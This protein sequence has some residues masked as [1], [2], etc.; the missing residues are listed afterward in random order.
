MNIDNDGMIDTDT[1]L[2]SVINNSYW[3]RAGSIVVKELIFLD[4]LHSYYFEKLSL[5]EDDEY[6]DLKEQL[7]WEGSVMSTMKSEEAHFITAVASNAKGIQI[8]S[9]DEYDKLKSKLQASNSWVVSR[10]ADPLAKSGLDT[11]LSYL[12][13]AL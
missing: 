4:C 1:F 3:L 7:T 9:D 13:L 8:M 10:K 5:L 2:K 6:N 11:F 12:K